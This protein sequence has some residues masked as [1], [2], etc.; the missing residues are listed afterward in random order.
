MQLSHH[1]DRPTVVVTGIGTVTGFG[2]GVE[3]LA[4]GLL[5]GRSC[6][7]PHALFTELNGEINVAGYV[8]DVPRETPARANHFI[9][10]AVG[11]AILAASLSIPVAELSVFVA[12]IHGNIDAWWRSRVTGAPMER[13]LWQ[14][15]TDIWPN[16][17]E[18]VTVTTISTGCTSSTI[19]IGQALDH[20]R[21]SPGAIAL[22]ASAEGFTPF[23]LEG[24][25][26]LR[27]LAKGTCRPFDA[28]RDGLVVGEGAAVLVL[29]TLAHAAKRGVMP[30]AE[31]AGFGVSA[32][33]ASFAAP[34]PAGR[35]VSRALEQA[36][37]DAKLEV[38]P[39]SINA[40]GSGTR[41]NDQMECI[42]LE[43][44]FGPNAR[45]RIPITSSKPA[46][47]HLCGA[48]G[49]IE[50]ICSIL[51]M[52]HDVVPPILNLEQPD[53]RF[54]NF[55]FVVGMPRRLRQNAVI[56]MNSALGGTNSAI[57]I[58]QLTS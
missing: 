57:V 34:D 54:G 19:A 16:V 47:G 56:S 55:D 35:G 5:S 4:K 17:A 23:L 13:G 38:L 26:A 1:R 20:L 32:D 41:L 40:H 31:I 15:G 11:E 58:R 53:R 21:T 28:R 3:A 46:L 36:L 29:E 27:T 49:A 18:R 25:K 10:A 48:A 30:L 12:S 8:A 42:A 45:R 7:R 14:L 2:Y 33:G 52:Q 37:C 43:R 9:K 22:V 6:V 51:G 44:V 39:D 50:V 24:L